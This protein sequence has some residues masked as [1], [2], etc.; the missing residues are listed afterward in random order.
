M[1]NLHYPFKTE[2]LSKLVWSDDFTGSANTGVDTSKWLYT[3]GTSYPGGAANFGTSEV[4]VMTSSTKNVYHDGN[5]NLVIEAIRD[6][7]GQ[8][9]AGRIET[10]R[11]DFMPPSG[12]TMIV[13]GRMK[14]PDYTGISGSGYWPAFWML[15]KDFRG[16]YQN[17]PG[18][19]EIDIMENVNGASTVYGTLHCN[20]IP[21]GE[22]NEST[23]KGGNTI[24]KSGTPQSGFHTYKV[25][26]TASYIKWFVDGDNYFTLA[27]SQFTDSTWKSITNHGYFIILNLAMGGSFPAA[28]GGSATS[29]T[30]NNGKFVIDYVAVWATSSSSSPIASPTSRVVSPTSNPGNCS[31]QSTCNGQSYDCSAY[32]CTGGKLCPKSAPNACGSACYSTSAYSCCNGSLAPAGQCLNGASP[33]PATTSPTSA[34]VKLTGDQH[35]ASLEVP[36]SSSTNGTRNACE[37]EMM[38]EVSK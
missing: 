31:G 26:W 34:E 29:A 11:T 23:G 18:I 22:C 25:E 38:E 10:V 16:N 36:A 5:G 9:T 7:S 13:E 37:M 4:E 15:G 21:G 32:V 3:T 20:V 19:G 8:W 14:L 27:K 28:L 2:Q 30:G 24:P 1:T 17:W 35:V 12:G 33:T 6:S